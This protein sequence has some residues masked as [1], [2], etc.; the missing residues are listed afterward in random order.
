MASVI[1]ASRWEASHCM[2]CFYL[3]GLLGVVTLR[4]PLSLRTVLPPCLTVNPQPDPVPCDWVVRVDH[5]IMWLA[6]CFAE[7]LDLCTG[8]F[9]LA[10]IPHPTNIL[11][12]IPIP[13]PPPHPPP[14]SKAANSTTHRD[15]V[16]RVIKDNL[17]KGSDDTWPCAFMQQCLTLLWPHVTEFVWQDELDSWNTTMNITAD[18]MY[19]LDNK[20]TNRTAVSWSCPHKINRNMISSQTGM[21]SYNDRSTLTIEEIAFSWSIPSNCSTHK[22]IQMLLITV[23]TIHTHRD[24]T[25]KSEGSSV[26]YL[27]FTELCCSH[28]CHKTTPSPLYKRI[29]PQILAFCIHVTL[30]VGQDHSNW[31]QRVS[32]LCM[33]VCVCVCVCACVCVC[34]CVCVCDH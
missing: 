9:Q 18:L 3:H 10:A 30:T 22:H 2:A 31:Y 12:K 15:P 16:V 6:V 1:C 32:K 14:Q 29:I 11:H 5:D 17:H 33:C 23:D 19:S 25:K 13:P 8:V 24:L 28:L 20:A 7:H 26:P 34:V 27:P 21:Q 4:E